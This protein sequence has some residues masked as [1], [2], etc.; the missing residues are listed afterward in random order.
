MSLICECEVNLEPGDKYFISP[1][2]YSVLDTSI[3]KRCCSC[4]DLINIGS[5]V[6]KFPRIKIPASEIECRIWGE[7]GEIPLAPYYLC[8]RDADL[9]FS[10][11]DLGFC[12]SIFDDMRDLAKEYNDTYIKKSFDGQ[13]VP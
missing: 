11:D 6:A 10:L 2:D 9:Y 4:G 7:G 12:V 13:G 5:T 8:E 1:D 3:R